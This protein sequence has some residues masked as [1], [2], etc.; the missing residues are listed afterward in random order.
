[1]KQ[2]TIYIGMVLLAMA[3]LSACSDSKSKDSSEQESGRETA[4]NDSPDGPSTKASSGSADT[5]RLTPRQLGLVNVDMIGYKTQ[6]LKP[7]ILANGVLALLPDS[8]AEVSSHIEGKINKI[9]VRE[10]QRVSAGQ[11]IVQLASFQLLELQNQYAEA[12]SDAE[13]LLAEYNRQNELRKSNIGVLSQYQS[14]DAKLKAARAREMSLR[15]KL[16]LIGVSPNGIGKGGSMTATLII[17]SPINGYISKFHE[18]IGS[19]VQPQTLLAEIINPDRIE[20]NVFVYEKDADF[21]REGQTIDLSFVNRSLPTV[22][23]TVAYISRAVDDENNAITLHV[24]F[25]RP[26]GELLAA[27]M[28][29]QARIVGTGEYVSKTAVPRTAILDDGEGK[30][31]FVTN[32]STADTI[33]FRKQ[34][35]EITRQGDQYVEVKPLG[36]LPAD[37]KIANNNVLALEAA[38][39]KGE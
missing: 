26:K 2:T 25:A 34:K 33:P 37:I 3:G 21:V 27:D 6:P 31:M 7:V 19:L 4:T 22:K 18:N 17:R 35:V 38:R 8:R 5:V 14:A 39:K 24:N 16:R 36:K 29:V 28:S 23:G 15:D 13:F 20:A 32:R 10:G 9:Y 30:F 11:P 1:M 12:H